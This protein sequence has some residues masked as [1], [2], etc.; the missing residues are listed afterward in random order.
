VKYKGFFKVKNSFFKIVLD[1]I[2]F[3]YFNGI[4]PTGEYPEGIVPE[5]DGMPVVA[6]IYIV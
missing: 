2:L 3:W 4:F 1:E 6:I 5:N